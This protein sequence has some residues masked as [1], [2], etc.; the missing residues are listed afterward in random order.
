MHRPSTT[1]TIDPFKPSAYIS[2]EPLSRE[3]AM[4]GKVAI[5]T[6]GA[7]GIGSA[8]CRAFADAG[9]GVAVADMDAVKG[10]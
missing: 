4:N 9:V 5:V 6:G 2:P 8:V 3:A 7:G 10:R 1:D